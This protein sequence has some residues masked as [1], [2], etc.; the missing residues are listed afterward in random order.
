MSMITWILT[1][2]SSKNNPPPP[3]FE[4]KTN[5]FS[6]KKVKAYPRLGPLRERPSE[7]SSE[8]EEEGGSQD[9]A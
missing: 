6:L 8:T 9:M 4:T 7:R 1:T 5:P 2:R 3:E